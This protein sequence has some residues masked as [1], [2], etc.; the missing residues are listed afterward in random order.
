MEPH[1]VLRELREARGLTQETLAERIGVG[2]MWVSYRET[3]RTRIGVDDVRRIH[4]VMPLTDDE[5]LRLIG[6]STEAAAS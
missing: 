6:R 3:G 1:E 2:P 4:A 5:A